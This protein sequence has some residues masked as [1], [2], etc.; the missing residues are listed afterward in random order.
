MFD[1]DDLAC[2]GVLGIVSFFS[3]KGGEQSAIK[4]M[5]DAQKEKE[6]IDLRKKMVE[7]ERKLTSSSDS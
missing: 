2:L 1:W 3:F 5:S 4:S 7:L 6:I